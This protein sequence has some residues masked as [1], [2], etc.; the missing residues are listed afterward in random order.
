[1]NKLLKSVLKAT[2]YLLN[3][4]AVQVDRLTSGIS[5]LAD[6]ARNVINPEED[7]TLRNVMSFAIGLGVG[8]G[9]GFLL[10]PASGGETRASLNNKVHEIGEKVRERFTDKMESRPTGT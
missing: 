5:D 3:E 9:T 1:M 7:H 2:I 4:P 8:I 10:A 6:Q